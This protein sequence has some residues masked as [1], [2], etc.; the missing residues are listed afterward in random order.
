MAVIYKV[1]SLVPASLHLY[2]ICYSAGVDR[3]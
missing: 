2:L 3:S 1:K